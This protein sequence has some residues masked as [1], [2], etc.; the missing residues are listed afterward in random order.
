MNTAALN[1]PA[2]IAF[3]A[4]W[5]GLVGILLAAFVST[6]NTQ[7]S[8][9]GL[10]DIR[11][12]VHAGFDEGAWIT[13]AHTVAQ[14]LVAPVAI[15]LGG[16]YGPRRVLIR[17]ALA[18]AF[19]SFLKPFAA[20]LWTLLFLQFAGGLASGF[21]VP[22]T[23]AFILRTMPPKLWAYGIAV[24]A[25]NLELSLN[26][27]ASLE[28]W[29]VDNRSWHWIFWQ[30]VPVALGMAFFLFVGATP[31]P[32]P[33][34]DAPPADQFGL[35][36][37]G[38]GLALI[39]AA[40]DQGNRLD[41]LN[42]GAVCG[43]L[44]AGVL[45]MAAFIFHEAHTPYPFV[46]LKVVRT[47]PIPQQ[48]GLI[49]MVRLMIFST[50]YVIPQFLGA[51]RGFRA[52]E[53][54]ETLIW[55]AIPQLLVCVVAGLLLRRLDARL[56]ILFGFVAVCVACLI[57]AHGLTPLWGTDQFLPSELIQAVGQS[58][59][60]TGIIFYGVLNLPPGEVLSFGATTQIARLFGGEIGLAFVTTFA[61]V[62]GQIASNLIGTH[63]QSGNGNVVDRL[64]LYAAA[65]SRVGNPAAGPL[66]ATRMLG[67][68]VHSAAIT[69]GIID[70]FV[71]VAGLSALG[72][73]VLATCKPAPD[74]PASPRPLFARKQ[75]VG[76]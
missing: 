11:G 8:Q 48:F 37:C 4:P 74:G 44:S 12:A 47:P 6:L 72:L 62:R 20:D 55:I 50:A 26:I 23:I 59:A 58:F 53:T 65:T 40:L 17:A 73:L 7:L 13:T 75:T 54:G 34:S 52:L 2:P 21:F 56:L 57:V 35:A 42:S 41:W 43:L 61:R 30:S 16:I 49:C 31:D 29:Y 24:Y 25:L 33:K 64:Q 70:T 66:R 63:L 60:L 46:K 68:A 76:Q 38:I 36:T 71:A 28:G 39:Y 27:S 19:I 9:F 1:R 5:L 18:F 14:M 69:Q 22:L 67:N 3:G 10:A 45:L 15:W 32:P 51:V